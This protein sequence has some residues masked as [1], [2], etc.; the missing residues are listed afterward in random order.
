MAVGA[1]PG[2]Q[3]LPPANIEGQICSY[4]CPNSDRVGEVA[5]QL[6]DEAPRIDTGSMPRNADGVPTLFFGPETPTKQI[7]RLLCGALRRVEEFCGARH[8]LRS[9]DDEMAV[10]RFWL[11][12]AKNQGYPRADGTIG[13]R[14]VATGLPL[15][16]GWTNHPLAASMLAHSV[17]D[18]PFSFSGPDQN[19]VFEPWAVNRLRYFWRGSAL[20]G[21]LDEMRDCILQFRDILV[22]RGVLAPRRDLQ[23]PGARLKALWRRNSYDPLEMAIEEPGRAARLQEE[24]FLH[25]SALSDKGKNG[26]RHCGRKALKSKDLCRLCNKRWIP[27]EQAQLAESIVAST[28]GGRAASATTPP[29]LGQPTLPPTSPTSPFK[30]CSGVEAAEGVTFSGLH[31]PR[32]CGFCGTKRSSVWKLSPG[33]IT[34]RTPRRR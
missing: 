19:A 27:V 20:L 18:K 22:E 2:Q 14:D 8:P 26:C 4:P 9:E 13:V 21:F 33:M 10:Y 24:F 5:A 1:S 15:V 29:P 31:L 28:G 12:V 7:A 23:T 34:V 11:G 16:I 6:L 3:P 17:H 30:V 25:V 32:E